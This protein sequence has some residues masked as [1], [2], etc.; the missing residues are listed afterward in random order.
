[1]ENKKY[2]AVIFDLG[3]VYFRSGFLV[4][5]ELSEEEGFDSDHFLKIIKKKYLR[6]L[7]TGK[8]T[9]KEFWHRFKRDA[10]FKKSIAE[11]KNEF[12]SFHK[13]TS[14]MKELVRGLRGK[15]KLGLLTNNTKE[16]YER[17]NKTYKISDE[18]DKVLVSADAKRRKPDKKIYLMMTELLGVKPEECIFIDDY[19]E[20]VA[21]ANKAGMKSIKFYS[22][23]KL[24]GELSKL[25]FDLKRKRSPKRK[26]FKKEK[27][28]NLKII[29]IKVNG[30]SF[31]TKDGATILKALGEN[32]FYV[33]TLC[34]AP[35][36]SPSSSCRICLVEIKGECQLKT[37]CSTKVCEG[38]E[39][40]TETKRVEK[41]R[42]TNLKLL[43]QDHIGKC[44]TCVRFKNCE[45]LKL[46]SKY[47]AGA[48]DF[49]GKERKIPIDDS[50]AVV[51]DMSKCIK[52]RRCIEACK[53]YGSD[54]LEIKNRGFYSIVGTK[55][56]KN[57]KNS[58]CISCL[59]CAQVCPVGA[60]YK[61]NNCYPFLL[62]EHSLLEF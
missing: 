5:N 19:F 1:M 6:K 37:A 38:M 21:G 46:V 10:G 41:A 56:G 23:E 55:N 44:P 33:P 22:L 25:G 7:E 30:K 51:F 54:V 14:G 8:M 4:F 13:P 59:Q 57:L 62:P 48:P 3:G 2:K 39:I 15:Y 34:Y 9:E 31:K 60:I 42:Q 12:L 49:N 28:E 29:N 32:G 58:G 35:I 40:L 43:Y 24:K 18:F 36:F 26:S 61:K 17:I 27:K 20:N 47:K 11:V 16:W 53:K 45:L 50:G 52:C